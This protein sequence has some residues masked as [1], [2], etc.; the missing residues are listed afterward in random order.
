M[1]IYTEQCQAVFFSFRWTTSRPSFSHS[2][3]SHHYVSLFRYISRRV[4][5]RLVNVKG[6]RTVRIATTSFQN[7]FFFYS[8]PLKRSSLKKFFFLNWTGKCRDSRVCHCHRSARNVNATEDTNFVRFNDSFIRVS[9]IFASPPPP[10]TVVNPSRSL[11]IIDRPSIRP[12]V[13]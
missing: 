6:K 4:T 12:I 2:L 8:S 11:P 5:Y 10:P 13:I 9:A 7:G 1:Y 3:S